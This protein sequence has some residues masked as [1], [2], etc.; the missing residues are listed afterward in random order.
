MS[1]ITISTM[2]T[3]PGD[4]I[5]LT[6]DMTLVSPTQVS[7]TYDLVTEHFPDFPVLVVPK[8]VTVTPRRD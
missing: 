1:G 8:G 4:T 5:V 2:R 3:E 7:D 6:Y